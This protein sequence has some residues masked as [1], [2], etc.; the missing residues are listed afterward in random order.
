M[1]SPSS[2]DSLILLVGIVHDRPDRGSAGG[3]MNPVELSGYLAE[4]FVLQPVLAGA[5]V[6]NL[7]M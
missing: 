6:G 3:K 1:V 4:V 2:V 7:R 5:L